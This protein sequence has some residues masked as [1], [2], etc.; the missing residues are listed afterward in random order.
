MEDLIT[1]DVNDI[2]SMFECDGKKYCALI[3]SEN[4][5]DENVYFALISKIDEK[6]IVLTNVLDGEL[7]KVIKEYEKQETIMDILNSVS[8][9]EI[10]NV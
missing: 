1:I 10:K 8:E 2:V 3:D 5:N 6:N 7:E 4:K 9:E